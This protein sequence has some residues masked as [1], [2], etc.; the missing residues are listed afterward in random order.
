[1]VHGTWYMP[2]LVGCQTSLRRIQALG[3]SAPFQASRANSLS[4]KSQ[5]LLSLASSSQLVLP[6]ASWANSWNA[7]SHH[8][9]GLPADRSVPLVKAGSQANVLYDHFVPLDRSN[10]PAH[11]HFLRRYWTT[12]P[13]MFKEPVFP[14][15]L[16][17]FGGSD[18]STIPSSHQELAVSGHQRPF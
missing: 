13:E 1:M 15:P 17:C 8:V 16:L 14:L 12:Q 7:D 9:T 5:V 2:V 11:C 4:R 10:S 18:Q 3:T 6:N